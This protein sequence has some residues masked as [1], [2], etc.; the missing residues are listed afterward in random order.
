MS[1]ILRHYLTRVISVIINVLSTFIQGF[2]RIR[3]VEFFYLFHA[4]KL[5][6]YTTTFF[7]SFD[8]NVLLSKPDSGYII[9]GR[10][11]YPDDDIILLIRL[12]ASLF[13]LILTVTTVHT[14]F[15]IGIWL[16]PIQ[17][18]KVLQLSL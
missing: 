11:L 5:K 17:S 2:V 12:Y 15:S 14:V 16:M 4:L 9:S 7:Q 3:S 6:L 8:R 1:F 13:S 10:I 18:L